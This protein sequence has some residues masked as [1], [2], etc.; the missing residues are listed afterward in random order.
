MKRLLALA[1]MVLAIDGAAAAADPLPLTAYYFPRSAPCTVM[2]D[3]QKARDKVAAF[4]S[5][6]RAIALVRSMAVEFDKKG[7][8]QCPGAATV[9]MIAVFIGGVDIYGRPD[10]GNRT[11]LLKLEGDVVKLKRLAQ[12]GGKITLFQLRSMFD[13][14]IY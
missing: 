14:E 1:G 7:R 11:T 12:A 4:S 5:Q 10:F 8:E 13:L 2:A 3:F 6:E 9:R